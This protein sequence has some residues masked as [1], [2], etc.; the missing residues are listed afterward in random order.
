M[1]PVSWLDMYTLDDELVSSRVLIAFLTEFYDTL[2]VNVAE[3]D[4]EA[5]YG[6]LKKMVDELRRNAIVPEEDF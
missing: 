5:Y 1:R 4:R 6:S 2:G 3:A